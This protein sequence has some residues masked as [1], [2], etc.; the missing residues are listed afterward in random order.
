MS[1]AIARNAAMQMIFE[2]LSG[3]QGG[4]ETLRMVYDELREEG[5]K[6]VGQEDP[7]LKDRAY[8][9]AAFEGVMEHLEE[10]DQRLE[11]YSHNWKLERMGAVDLTILR[12]AAWEIL[13]ADEWDVP[14]SVAISEA[15]HLAKQYADEDS[16]RF[17]N[18]V[19][20]SLLRDKE[21][22]A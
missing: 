10:I 20:G 11:K 13:Y 21:A 4:E 1:R 12:L 19:L 14:G 5:L 8:I 16:G 3:G 18:G 22:E 15:V 17:I 7:S 2:R 6:T 9:Q